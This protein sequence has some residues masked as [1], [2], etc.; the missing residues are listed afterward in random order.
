MDLS[1]VLQFPGGIPTSRVNSAQQWDFPNAWAPLVA[2]LVE[3]LASSDVAK[4]REAAKGVG[5]QWVESNYL[6]WK[7]YGHM[8]EKVRH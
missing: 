8:F 1:G 2:L 4:A 5:S 6:A 7:K 3:A